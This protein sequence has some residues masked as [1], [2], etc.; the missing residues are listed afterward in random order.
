L[1]F[2]AHASISSQQR[3]EAFRHAQL[4]FEIWNHLASNINVLPVHVPSIR[5]EPHI[6]AKFARAEF[7]ISPDTPI[8]FVIN[9]I[10]KNGVVVLA[11]PTTL[12][13]RDAFSLWAGSEA[14]KP[15][16]AIT[17]GSSGDRV[18]WS[19][20]HELGHL[21]MHHPIRAFTGDPEEQANQFAAEFL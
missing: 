17:S 20:A 14:R 13:K 12:E 5:L 19:A 3:T 15:V 2:R 11:I 9:L 16:V 7:G 8:P 21:I 1:L 18:A 6:A 4:L 10:E